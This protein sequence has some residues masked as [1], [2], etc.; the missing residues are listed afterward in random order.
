MSHK[1]CEKV[2]ELVPHV[3]HCAL[4]IATLVVSC[5][6][7]HK[8]CHLRKALRDFKKAEEELKK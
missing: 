4:S 1:E 8:V 2:R 5:K 7:L 6:V 3:V